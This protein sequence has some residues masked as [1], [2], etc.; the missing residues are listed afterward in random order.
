MMHYALDSQHLLYVTLFQNIVLNPASLCHALSCQASPHPCAGPAGPRGSFPAGGGASDPPS[1]ELDV[2]RELAGAMRPLLLQTR[3]RLAEGSAGA[4]GKAGGR[5]QELLRHVCTTACHCH[6]LIHAVVIQALLLVPPFS[7]A[8]RDVGPNA[9]ASAAV[10]AAEASGALPP[11]A[12]PQRA[13][14][15]AFFARLA[16]GLGEGGGD[17]DG[18]ESFGEGAAAF[19]SACIA[20]A[21]ICRCA[22][23]LPLRCEWGW[24]APATGPADPPATPCWPFNAQSAPCAPRSAPLSPAGSSGGAPYGDDDAVLR[25]RPHQRCAIRQPCQRSASC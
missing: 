2:D 22:P 24:G 14:V 6:V 23:V 7:P 17:Q 12:G 15:E 4:R 13:A 18:F 21:A 16:E 10:A 3:A 25:I 5:Q 1:R 11:L 19:V 9:I 20:R 8:G